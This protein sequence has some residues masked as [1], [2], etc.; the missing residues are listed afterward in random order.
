MALPPLYALKRLLRICDCRFTQR[1]QQ[2]HFRGHE[3]LFFAT[4]WWDNVSQEI[5]DQEIA[6]YFNALGDFR[7]TAVVDVGAATG[8]FSIAAA[9]L[10]P[11]AKIYAFEPAVRQRILLS[12]NAKL[13]R[14]NR[15]QIAPFGLWSHSDTLAFRTVGAESSFADVSRFRGVLD[16]PEK[17]AVIS[18]DQWIG[19]NKIQRVDLIKMDAEGAE[20]EILK[21]ATTTLQRFHPRL[22][23]QAYHSREGARTFERCVEMLRHHS[24]TID[25]Y[26]PPSGLLRAI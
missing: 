4:R 7:P 14:A 25:E 5:F 16:F 15:I 26:A 19:D 24:Y 22:L 1:R 11:E 23:I 2:I 10:F 13:N 17:V 20:I 8:H 9:R 12:R 3:F 21:G 6:P 18:L